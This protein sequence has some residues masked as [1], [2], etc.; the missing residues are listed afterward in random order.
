MWKIIF[1]VERLVTKFESK[2]LTKEGVVFQVSLYHNSYAGVASGDK[3]ICWMPLWIIY[4][5]LS[6]CP[7]ENMALC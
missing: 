5:G 4:W 1:V 3:G 6:F 2:L 7:L